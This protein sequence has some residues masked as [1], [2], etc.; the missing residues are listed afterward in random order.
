[1]VGD[2]YDYL[3]DF[4]PFRF[5]RWFHMCA[6]LDLVAGLISPVVNGVIIQSKT[7]EGLGKDRPSSLAGRL[8]LGKVFRANIW[9]ESPQ[10]GGNLQVFGRLLDGQQ[11]VSITAGPECGRS[12]DYLAWNQ[13][14]NKNKTEENNCKKKT[15]Q[16]KV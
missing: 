9:Q 3:G 15:G 5:T 2:V 6:S 4:G 1:M 8:V 16:P 13:V 10:L 14:N 7:V 12:G 11:M